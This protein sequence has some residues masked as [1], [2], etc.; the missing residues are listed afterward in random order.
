MPN[1]R[2]IIFFSPKGANPVA[3]AQKVLFDKHP[4]FQI[5]TFSTSKRNSL[6]LLFYRD[7]IIIVRRINEKELGLYES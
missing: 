5:E 2:Q 4:S 3:A 1:A 7:L 6:R